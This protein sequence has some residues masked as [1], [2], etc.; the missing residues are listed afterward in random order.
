MNDIFGRVSSL[1]HRGE[2]MMIAGRSRV[3]LQ[4]LTICMTSRLMS[5][6]RRDRRNDWYQLPH[7]GNCQILSEIKRLSAHRGYFIQSADIDCVDFATCGCQ[8][9]GEPIPCMYLSGQDV[10]RP[11]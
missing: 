5:F 3:T 1:L 6:R 10:C 8:S 7:H 11:T 9:S 4:A 2:R